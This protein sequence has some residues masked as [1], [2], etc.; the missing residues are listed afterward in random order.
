MNDI[1]N[2]A[3]EYEKT[4]QI[5]GRAH[6]IAAD[7][8]NSL[9]RLFGIPV[10]IITAVVGTTIFS[11]LDQNPNP[12][13]KIVAG[14]VSLTG[15]VLAS[16]QTSLGFAQTAQ[17]Y[18]AAGE[19]YRAIR[20]KFETFQLKYSTVGAEQR[21]AVMT[22]FEGLVKTLDEVPKEFPTV[23]DKCYEKAKQEIEAKEKSES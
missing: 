15:T 19:S 5:V 14:L 12:A 22:E 18:K 4:Y 3:R 10:I 7:R 8:F 2:K 13:W 20:R 23:P 16:L 21:G 11:T 6:Y 17:K 9:N 1:I